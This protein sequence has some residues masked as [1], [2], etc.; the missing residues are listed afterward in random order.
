[1]ERLLRK[2]QRISRIYSFPIQITFFVSIGLFSDSCTTGTSFQKD[3]TLVVAA[4]D[5]AIFT[6]KKSQLANILPTNI[7]K[8]L[9]SLDEY[10]NVYDTLPM[11]QIKKSIFSSDNW[12][13]LFSNTVIKEIDSLLREAKLGIPSE[14]LLVLYKKEDPL[15]PLTKILRTSLIILK[16]N[17]GFIFVLPDINQNITFPSQYN[18][19]DWTL[20]KIPKVF[21]SNK[22]LLKIKINQIP[23]SFYVEQ[24]GDKLSQYDRIMIIK[25]TEL[26][27]NPPFYRF[28]DEDETNTILP[29][30][31]IRDRFQSL[32]KLKEDG[33]ITQ[34][35]YEKKRLELLKDL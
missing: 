17:N 6:I 30:K 7:Q 33:L 20:Y 24:K 31:D 4:S 35:E 25:D 11:I 13:A 22:E 12:E 18:F 1:M 28:V 21:P 26:I 29:K 34:E 19:E 9:V 10:P 15:S 14:G 8:S 3:Q 32:E 2:G 23:M 5:L 27:S 16:T